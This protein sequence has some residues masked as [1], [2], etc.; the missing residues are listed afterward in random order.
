[1]RAEHQVDHGVGHFD[2]LRHM[3]LLHHAA[4]HGDYL[5]R[6]G[7]LGVVERADVAQHA[8]LRMLAHGA[9]ID[10]DNVRG[11]LILRKAAAHL[12]KVAAQLL[13]V[14]LI[15]LAAVGVH[16]SQHR[17]ALARIS[18]CDLPADALLPLYFVYIYDLSL[19][20]H[21]YILIQR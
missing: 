17:P 9:G 13:A 19:V 21:S 8:H 4:A 7:L 11:K 20:A 2:L 5:A 10:N 12:G 14:G 6:A 3:L 15:L 18:L 1:M 16:H